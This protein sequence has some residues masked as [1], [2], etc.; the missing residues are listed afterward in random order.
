M[1]FRCS[2]TL[3]VALTVAWASAPAD[4]AAKTNETEVPAKKNQPEPEPNWNWATRTIGGAQLWTDHLHRGGY[5]LQQNAL[6]KHWRLLDSSDVRRTWGSREQCLSVLDTELPQA[7]QANQPRHVVIL[8]HGL[9]RTRQSMIP[10]EDKLHEE[11]YD[12]TIR[13]AYASTRKSIGDSAVALREMLEDYPAN[14]TFSFIGHSMGNIV[15]RHMVG[16]VQRDGDPN[17]LLDRCESMVMLGPPNQGAMISKRLAATGLYGWVAGKGGL[18]LGP[19]W[20]A[21]ADKLATPPF[22]FA[23]IAGDVSNIPVQNP[24]ID[25][26]SDFVVSLE[27]ADLEGR[28]WL[29]TVP[30]L[31]SFL[32]TDLV[33][34]DMTI[35]FIKEHQQ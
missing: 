16:D 9:F 6:T 8:L 24:L 27:E 12:E 30:V 22:P 35:D 13:Y 33:T 21:I 15:V 20:D 34:M 17:R 10:L 29:K 18:E 28:E 19:E 2:L 14:T 7:N 3:L 11:G 25:G 31:H 1:L 5:R 26:S 4:D 23:I 32:M